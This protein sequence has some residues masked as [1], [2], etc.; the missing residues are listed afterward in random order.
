MNTHS[1]LFTGNQK[2]CNLCDNNYE[3]LVIN[4]QCYDRFDLS[5]LSNQFID[6]LWCAKWK[7][8]YIN[9]LSKLQQKHDEIENV[10]KRPSL[11]NKK[12]IK[13]FKSKQEQNDYYLRDLQS[14]PKHGGSNCHINY[15][16]YELMTNMDC[17]MF[18]GCNR[19][20]INE[21]AQIC[22]LQIPLVF[23]ARNKMRRYWPFGL[24]SVAF[25][26][27]ES[28]YKE[29][30][31]P[32]LKIMNEKYAKPRL[33]NDGDWSKQYWTRQRIKNNT[34]N[35]VQRLRG[36][37]KDDDICI[38]TQD[39]TYQ[40]TKTNQRNFDIRKKSL[41][42]HKHH[43]LIKIH[44]IATANGLPILPF[45]TFADGHHSDGIIFQCL[46]DKDYVEKCIKYYNN[47]L[48][49]DEYFV[50]ALK[51]LEVCKQMQYLHYLFG[52][53]DEFICD[54]GYI[55]NDPRTKKPLQP[56][57]GN[58]LFIYIYIIYIFIIYIYKNMIKMD[59]HLLLLPLT[60]DQLQR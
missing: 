18:T 33:I 39:S 57:K 20:E 6:S 15:I 9:K 60:N 59:E 29:H 44:I 14:I 46:M 16:E 34:P 13:K 48:D 32:T 21:Q 54:N 12:V 28:W 31:H 17:F 55:I 50:P 56:P 3:T 38:I 47:K 45:Y 35:F 8:F 43:M 58:Y 30:W 22:G 51:S 36:V 26:R 27:S 10:I 19:Y 5:K 37:S 49:N 7:K 24:Q 52:M 11:K 41:S 25:G 23:A 4:D 40:Y 42:P 2:I 53:Q 1:V